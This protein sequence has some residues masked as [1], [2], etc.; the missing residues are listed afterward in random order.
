MTEPPSLTDTQDRLQTEYLGDIDD[1]TSSEQLN[2]WIENSLVCLTFLAILSLRE[3]I[4]FSPFFLIIP[5]F[6]SS[7]KQMIMTLVRRKF[8]VASLGTCAF[9]CEVAAIAA[10]LSFYIG[11][12]CLW[13]QVP[14]AAL[15]T[16]LILEVV[17]KIVMR[18]LITSECFLFSE[19]V[20]TTYVI[21]KLITFISLG[22]KFDGYDGFT[23][24][25]V[26]WPCWMLISFMSIVTLGLFLLLIGSFCTWAV[27]EAEAI[28]VLASAWMFIS[29]FGV[30]FSL[31]LFLITV[32]HYMDDGDSF[33]PNIYYIEAYLLGFLLFTIKKKPELT[34][35]WNKFFIEEAPLMAEP[36]IPQGNMKKLFFKIAK[37]PSKLLV[38]MSSTYYLPTSPK[39]VRRKSDYSMYHDDSK[40][41]RR[42]RF[43][44]LNAID[45][46]ITK[47]HIDSSPDV[48]ICVICCDKSSNSVI[49]P[50]GHAGLCYTCAMEV[51]KISEHCH[52]CR[53]K[54]DKVLLIPEE[55][56]AVVRPLHATEKDDSKSAGK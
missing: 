13:G 14:T 51:W 16:P 6:I 42:I 31:S 29:S 56:A 45:E 39:Q 40:K 34:V 47:Q 18:W 2:R 19:L 53:T 8:I 49:L 17:T 46:E 33:S 41:E 54:I 38:R 10:N 43:R 9:A 11:L 22:F 20:F 12:P 4:E 28:E 1:E 27:N 26:F 30:T 5:L 50:C 7:L 36:P 32:G 44:S 23:W 55:P 24:T 3:Y 37:A 15:A 35:W 21:T 48:K 25:S 52:F